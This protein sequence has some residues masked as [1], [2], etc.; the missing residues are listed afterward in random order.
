MD[1]NKQQAGGRG[2]PQHV[3]QAHADVPSG[4]W[5][6]PNPSPRSRRSVR[7]RGLVEDRSFGRGLGLVFYVWGRV[8]VWDESWAGVGVAEG[9]LQDE[10]GPGRGSRGRVGGGQDKRLGRREA[11]CPEREIRSRADGVRAES[12]RA[13]GGLR[14]EQHVPHVGVVHH[15]VRDHLPLAQEQHL[16][17]REVLRAA[18]AGHREDRAHRDA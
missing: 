12:G 13:G 4:P 6:F 2:P 3:A 9:D 15:L 1:Q 17:A 10:F 11:R 7:R 5:H 8:G 16:R 14:V 18:G